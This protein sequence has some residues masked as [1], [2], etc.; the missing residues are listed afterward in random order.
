MKPV[1][2]QQCVLN[3]GNEVNNNHLRGKKRKRFN[4]CLHDH[5]L[6]GDMCSIGITPLDWPFFPAVEVSL[7]V[8]CVVAQK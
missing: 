5:A 3:Y 8:G 7:L 6:L 4:R 2:L 1:I